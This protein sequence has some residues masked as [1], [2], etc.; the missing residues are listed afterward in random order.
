MIIRK[1][2]KAEAAHR[3][4]GSYTKRCQGLHGHSYQFEI[5]LKSAHQD[6]AQMLMDFSL[7]SDRFHN[8]LDAFDHSILVWDQDEVL[9]RS[10]HLLNPRVMIVPYNTTAEQIARHLYY[11]GLHLNLPMHKVIVHETRTGCAEF[12]GDDAITIALEAIQYSQAIRDA[13][14]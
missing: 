4:I 14:R 6:E 5:F 12:T 13:W 3:L 2:F 10:A 7:L 11:Q 8:A 1:S 9:L